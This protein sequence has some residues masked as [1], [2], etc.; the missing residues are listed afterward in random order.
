MNMQTICFFYRE[1]VTCLLLKFLLFWGF[2]WSDGFSIFLQISA[3]K[4]NLGINKNLVPSNWLWFHSLL[5]ENV[6]DK[7]PCFLCQFGMEAEVVCFH[8][9]VVVF[10]LW[11]YEIF[12]YSYGALVSLYYSVN[13]PS[14]YRCQVLYVLDGM[15]STQAMSSLRACILLIEAKPR[16]HV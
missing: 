1:S 3:Q 12:H 7:L 2:R 9:Q 8:S 4:V 11:N 14:D 10:V 5:F 13:S 16:G 15:S 6:T